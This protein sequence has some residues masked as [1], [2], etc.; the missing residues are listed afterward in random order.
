MLRYAPII[1]SES[2]S[3]ISAETGDTSPS[4]IVNDSGSVV[5]DSKLPFRYNEISDPLITATR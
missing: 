2:F 5:C 3:A 1:K 4:K